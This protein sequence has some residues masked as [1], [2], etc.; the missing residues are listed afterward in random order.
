MGAALCWRLAGEGWRV[1]V[2]SRPGANRARLAGLDGITVLDGSLADASSLVAAVAAAEPD[3]VFH[4][5]STAFNPPP[6]MEEH[7]SVNVGGTFNLLKAL[8]GSG[9]RVVFTNSA[10][11]Y[12]AGGGLEEGRRPVPATWIGGT[13]AAAQ[14]LLET[15]ARLGG[16]SLVDVRLFTP[17]GPWERPGRLI[18]ATILAALDGRPI[19]ATAGLQRRDFVHMADVVEAL[20]KAGTW[21]GTDV[22]AVNIGSGTGVSVREVVSLILDLMDNPVKSE[23]GALPT[24]PDEIPEITADISLA[25]ERLGWRP[26]VGLA[27]GLRRTIAW[28]RD[29]KDLAQT[30]P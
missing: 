8:Q 11:I 9:A 10:A 19:R 29:H 2:L 17:Y 12:G 3:V 26:T 27:E 5:A 28:Y 16:A 18:P 13:K 30:L 20:V 1:H 4:M 22:L 25:A 21:S 15:H 7:F 23:F 6:A 14:M 24:R